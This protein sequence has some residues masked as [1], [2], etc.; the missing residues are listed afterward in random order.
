MVVDDDDDDDNDDDDDDDDDG[1]FAGAL[2]IRSIARQF[3]LS[4]EIRD[5]E[6]DDDERSSTSAFLFRFY[7][8]R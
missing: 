5:G 4:V 2:L 3:E 6:S 7:V 1:L 8:H